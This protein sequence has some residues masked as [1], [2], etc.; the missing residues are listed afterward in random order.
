MTKVSQSTCQNDD[1]DGCR[2]P[3]SR[4][5]SNRDSHISIILRTA[6]GNN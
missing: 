3:Y 1:D 6:G 5:S 2:V 4:V